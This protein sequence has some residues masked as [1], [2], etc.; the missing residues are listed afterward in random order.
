M[1]MKLTESVARQ[2]T[3][4][5]PGKDG[6]AERVEKIEQRLEGMEHASVVIPS[7]E[8]APFDQKV[9]EA[10]LH[11]VDARIHEY[12]GTVLRRIADAETKIAIEMQSLDRQHHS[13]ASAAQAASTALEARLQQVEEIQ[14]QAPEPI[15][16]VRAYVDEQIGV[17]RKQ[18]VSLN[19]EFAEAV[20]GIVREEVARQVQA[21][22][23]ELGRAL[24]EQIVLLVEA[25]LG[26]RQAGAADNS[27]SPPLPI[28]DP[29]PGSAESALRAARRAREPRKRR[30]SPADPASH[31]S[32]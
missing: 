31:T 17:L 21:R 30:V 25:A 27:A 16:E 5:A 23:A 6:L 20:A 24:Q 1:G 29:A 28:E 13:L 19:Q 7:G 11:A 14:S 4:A 15:A 32:E 10:L 8:G 26:Q 22:T 18:I 12:D 2:V 9:A 3:P